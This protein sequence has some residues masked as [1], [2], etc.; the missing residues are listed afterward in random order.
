[1]WYAA[2]MPERIPQVQAATPT[3]PCPGCGY[4]LVASGTTTCPECGVAV[5]VPSVR[6]ARA[7]LLERLTRWIGWLL[8]LRAAGW[9]VGQVVSTMP[10]SEHGSGSG[11]TA[12]TLLE[13]TPQ[14][15]LLMLVILLGYSEKRAQTRS[16]GLVLIGAALLGETLAIAFRIHQVNLSWLPQGFDWIDQIDRSTFVLTACAMIATQGFIFKCGVL[17]DPLG[18][19]SR[20]QRFLMLLGIGVIVGATFSWFG[21]S[22]PYPSSQ[23]PFANPGGAVVPTGWWH[24]LQGWRWALQNCGDPLSR[25]AWLLHGMV[26][27]VILLVLT[28]KTQRSKV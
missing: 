8:I 26:L 6:A 18:L 16:G 5:D 15:L 3:T 20:T 11:R 24:E 28:P 25:I 27:G 22:L 1:M 9:C 12:A 10:P 2:A 17:A 19:V 21:A 23:S 7:E 4:A 13:F 14:T